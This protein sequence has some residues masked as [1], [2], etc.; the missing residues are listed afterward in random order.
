MITLTLG[1]DGMG[2]DATEAD[3]S[4]WCSF[5][6]DRICEVTALPEIEVEPARLCD[7]QVNRITGADLEEQRIIQDALA[8]L[9][10]EWCSAGAPA[11]VPS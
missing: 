1:R 6:L 2:P 7:V 9:W 3:F 5:V 8:D 4:N 10:D 11:E